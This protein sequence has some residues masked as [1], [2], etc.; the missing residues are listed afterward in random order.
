MSKL[1]TFAGIT[2][3]VLTGCATEAAFNEQA[4]RWVGKNADDLVMQKGPPASSATLSNGNRVLQ[5]ERIEHR[6]SGGQS[7]TTYRSV[8]VNG[9]MVS[10]PVNNTIPVSSKTDTCILR[11]VVDPSNTIVSWNKTGNDCVAEPDAKK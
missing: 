3:I 10:V 2:A 7:Y 11:F 5:Y 4:Q 9:T 1:L 8:N 6:V